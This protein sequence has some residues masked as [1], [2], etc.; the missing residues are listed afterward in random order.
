MKFGPQPLDQA[1]G[2]ILAHS[3][4]LAGRKLAKGTKLAAADIA[5]L[6]ADGHSAV[7]VAML[8]PGDI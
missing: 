6:R 5:A 1:E 3:L 8:E 2:G 4:M 7:V